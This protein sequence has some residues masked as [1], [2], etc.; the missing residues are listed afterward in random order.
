M[1]VRRSGKRRRLV[2]NQEVV[3][4]HDRESERPTGSSRRKP[5]SKKQASGLTEN[6]RVYSG[7]AN[8]R[9]Q[10]KTTDLLPK[11]FLSCALVVLAL[12]A[13]IGGLNLMS[14]VSASWPE[15]VGD[16]GLRASALS[17][18]GTLA[19]WFKSFLLIMTGLASLQI[20]A[21]RQHRCD[22][23]RGTYRMWLWMSALFFVASVNCFVDLGAILAN[24]TASLTG[25]TAMNGIWTLAAVK[26][27]ALSA[28]VIRGLI[29]VRKSRSAL[30][31]VV[32]VWLAWSAAAVLQV[33]VVR[34]NLVIDYQVTYGNLMLFGTATLF[35]SVTLYARFVYLRAQGLITL[36]VR[37]E[38][39]VDEAVET[40]TIAPTTERS[41]SRKKKK[42]AATEEESAEQ[43]LDVSGESLEES[44]SSTKKRKKSKRPP[45]PKPSRPVPQVEESAPIPM[46]TRDQLESEEDSDSPI[47]PLSTGKRK[48]T[49]SERKRMAKQAKKNRRAA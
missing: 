8:R 22:D 43:D 15:V 4:Q 37:T 3:G 18:P 47:L 20:Y 29:E 44:G 42:A 10:K 39:V 2:V 9:H 48:L 35:I 21:L 40:E 28:L 13:C 19:G 46:K 27:I 6:Q 30:A 49:R 23:Y 7:S 1:T 17:G 11:R 5:A 24:V 36:P 45:V 34:D 31:L 26:L 25:S 14:S 12:A 33:P 32:L 41:A 38:A 16:A